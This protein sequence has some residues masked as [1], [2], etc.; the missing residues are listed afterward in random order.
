M[1]EVVRAKEEPKPH[2]DTRMLSGRY[3]PHTISLEGEQLQHS[4]DGGPRWPLVE[5]ADETF[6]IDSLRKPVRFTFSGQG[7]EQRIALEYSD[8]RK[9]E[10]KKEPA[11]P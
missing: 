5:V 4:Q 6:V 10:F 3:G 11:T 9:M 2:R 7:S 1:I 8:G